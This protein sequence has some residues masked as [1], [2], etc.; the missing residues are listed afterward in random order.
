LLQAEHQHLPVLD[1]IRGFA[2]LLV[3]L[4]HFYSI[5]FGWLGVDLFF[6]LSGFLITGILIGSKE[7]KHYFRNFYARRT[8]RIFPLYYFSL[9]IFYLLSNSNAVTLKDPEYYTKNA[10]WYFLYIQN[11]LYAFDGWPKDHVLNHFWSLAIEEQFYLF[12]PVVIYIVPSRHLLVTCISLI[13]ISLGS[14]YY[15]WYNG[16]EAPFQFV[17]T[18]C[19]LDG[20]AAGSAIAVLLR[21]HQQWLQKIA[22]VLLLTTVPVILLLYILSGTVKYDHYYYLTAGFTVFD[23]FWAAILIL[24]L[25]EYNM[26]HKFFSARWLTWLGKYSYGI[27]VYHWIIYQLFWPHFR[28]MTGNPL[29]ADVRYLYGTICLMITLIVAVGS[30]HLLESPL[31]RMK[32]HFA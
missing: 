23:L 25:K 7:N 32:K 20:L 31:L 30:Y 4:F 28:E 27:Y 22:S 6:V 3:I 13:F 12:W 29:I 9:I 14:R 2:V 16:M 21:T 11:W 17:A 8:L 15:T 5:G 1:G 19:R 24:S 26:L 18:I 10:E